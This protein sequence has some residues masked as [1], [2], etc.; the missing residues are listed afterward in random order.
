LDKTIKKVQ[1]L[2]EINDETVMTTMTTT[3]TATT[4]TTADGNGYD[5]YQNHNNQGKRFIITLKD[6]TNSKN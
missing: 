2:I 6:V 1:R 5:D 4:K 3:T